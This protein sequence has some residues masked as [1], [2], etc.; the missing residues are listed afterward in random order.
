M[1]A[2][3]LKRARPPT[4]AEV[5]GVVAVAVQFLEIGE[6]LV[7]VVQ[8]VGAL[9]V[10][11]D[12]R[13]LPG[14]QAGVDVLGELLALLAEAFDLVGD[15][16]RRLVLHVAQLVDLGFQLGDGLLEVEESGVWTIQ[17]SHA[18]RCTHSRAVQ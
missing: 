16:D 8:R 13:H 11:R 2:W 4:M 9:R 18:Q 12:L 15:V 5:V 7:H 14:R 1:Q 6:H 10:A 3:P 17:A